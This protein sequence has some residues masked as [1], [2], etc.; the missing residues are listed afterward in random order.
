VLVAVLF[1]TISLVGTGA[2]NV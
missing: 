2:R 1:I